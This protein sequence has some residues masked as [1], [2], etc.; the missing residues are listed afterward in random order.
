V[1]FKRRFITLIRIIHGGIINFVRNMSLS[2]AAMAIMV[3]TLTI[4]LFSIVANYTFT[5]T[6]NQITSKI[7]ISVYLN[8]NLSTQQTDQ[9]ISQIKTLP[10]VQHVQ[11]LS[12]AQALQIYEQQNASN[13][14]LI[15]AV[16]ETTNP[17]PA[18]IIIKP[19]N[20]NN[21][22][23]I[24]SFLDQPKVSALQ[25]SPPSYS[26]QEKLAIDRITHAT[27]VLQEIGV[28]AV[29]VFAVV[30]VL[31]IFNTIQMAIFNR[32]DEIQI[33]RLL[34]ASTWYIRGPFIV[35]SVIY[36]LF[37]GVISVLIINTAFQASS[38]TLQASSLGLLD[39][40]YAANFFDNRFL[41][42]LTIQLGLGIVIGAVS[43]LIATR[44]YL[45][46]KT[47]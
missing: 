18:T 37:S 26:G 4:V 42:L 7:D 8:N 29:I 47:K 46:F 31:I 32:R 17:I 40:G 38:T 22:S 1:N 2:I 23:T 27:S 34:G 19:I 43:S 11:Y 3:V 36:G 21:L 30:S 20:L 13:Q 33:M 44:R 35:E 39:I 10:N 25:T 14:Q 6:I 45:K 12:Q 5:N 28:V 9:L 15:A 24:K 41:E 16:N